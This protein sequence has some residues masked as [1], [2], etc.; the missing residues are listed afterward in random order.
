MIL[1]AGRG[2]RLRPL[3]DTV[4]KPALPVGGKPWIVR[5]LSYLR[6]QG[7]SRFIVNL[8][9]RKEELY[10]L[11]RPLPFNLTFSEEEELLGTGGGIR[12]ALVHWK[13]EGIWVHNGDVMAPLK[14]D[15]LRKKVEEDPLSPLLVLVPYWEEKIPPVVGVFVDPPSWIFVTGFHRP[16]SD[17]EIPLDF[18]GIFYLPKFLAE[19]LPEKGSVVE[20]GF[21]LWGRKVLLRGYLYPGIFLDIGT[22]QRYEKAKQLWEENLR[23]LYPEI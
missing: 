16:P 7:F 20:G 19:T 23:F 12:K 8:H 4:P 18:A 17:G 3:T 11:L 1:S 5:L 9:H 10:S 13:R 6:N 21:L 14:Y 22:P 15:L 2:E